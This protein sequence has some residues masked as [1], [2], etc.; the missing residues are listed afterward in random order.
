MILCALKISMAELK[1]QGHG[2]HGGA[3]LHGEERRVGAW[4][5]AYNNKYE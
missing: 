2:L 4:W 1:A 5:L 3:S